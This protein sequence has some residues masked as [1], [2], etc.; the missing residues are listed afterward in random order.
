MVG[1]P[2][3][4]NPLLS[5]NQPIDRE[6]VRLIFDGLTRYGVDG[7]LQPALAQSWQ[8]SEDGLSL[9]FN[10][11]QDATWHDGQP[12]TAMMLLLAMA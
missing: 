11:R 9:H 10:L 5:D 6:L 8:V 7:R 2:L 3:Y 1:A 4:L 12:V